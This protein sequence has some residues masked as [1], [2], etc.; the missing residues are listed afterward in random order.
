MKG[1]IHKKENPVQKNK[2]QAPTKALIN[3]LEYIRKKY[4]FST[5]IILKIYTEFQKDIVK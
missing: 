2:N 3:Y 1:C 5:Y 4:I